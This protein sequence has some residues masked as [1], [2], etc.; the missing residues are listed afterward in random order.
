MFSALRL[1]DDS[2][3]QQNVLIFRKFLPLPAKYAAELPICARLLPIRNAFFYFFSLLPAKG[4][5]AIRFTWY[6]LTIGAVFGMLKSKPPA[7]QGGGLALP[8][9]C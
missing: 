5:K 3:A 4:E 9:K 1:P 6:R 8:P 2:S 7:L